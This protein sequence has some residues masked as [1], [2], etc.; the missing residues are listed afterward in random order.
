MMKME[1]KYEPHFKLFLITNHT[2][3]T[4][5]E[6]AASAARWKRIK[7]IKFHSKWPQGK[8]EELR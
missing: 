8:E 2:P 4:A 7:I 1:Y 6:K 3:K 5:E